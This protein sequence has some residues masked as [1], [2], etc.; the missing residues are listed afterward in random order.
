MFARAVLLLALG[1]AASAQQFEGFPNGLTCKTGSGGTGSTT[2]TKIELQDAIIGP[3]GDK[4]D[5]SAANVASG[6][7]TSLS[8]IPFFLTGVTG[9]DSVT[10][11]FAYDKGKDTYHYCL[12]QGAVDET[13]WRSRLLN[14]SSI[15]TAVKPWY[16]AMEH[17]DTGENEN[18][19]LDFVGSMAVTGITVLSGE[20]SAASCPSSPALWP[21]GCIR[22]G[23]C[24]GRG[25]VDSVSLTQVGSTYTA[26]SSSYGSITMGDTTVTVRNTANSWLVCNYDVAY[27]P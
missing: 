14:F 10:V 9:K 23:G 17:G 11:G 25:T 22:V 27:L 16:A 12:A 24:P 15:P 21:V 5:N 4:N 2:I 7:C 26:A 19:M 8:G 3:Q 18:E 1:A 20:K 6:K 13:G